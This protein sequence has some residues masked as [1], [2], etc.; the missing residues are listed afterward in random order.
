MYV[1]LVIIKAT[2]EGGLFGFET[3][4]NAVGVLSLPDLKL[5]KTVQFSKDKTID[6]SSGTYE[7]GDY[8][9]IYG[10]ESTKFNKFMHVCR[11]S[12]SNPF[13]KM[14]YYDGTSWVSDAKQS[15]RLISGLSEQYSVF[16]YENKFY[17]L[18]QGNL[19]SP[20][21]YLWDAESAVGPFTNKR[22][23]YTTP[24]AGGDLITYN[25]MA[26]TEFIQNGELLV[27]YSINSYNGR[28]MFRNADTY[29]PYFIRVS[30]WQ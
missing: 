13:K 9:Y 10:A 18:S 23:I 15:A 16:K 4:G 3:I 29:R 19:L 21:I 24:Q 1:V 7:D 12:R 8:V 11:T 20:D 28:D 27:S 30:N 26:H 2:G 17:L 5:T 14:E 22:K 6:W 25:A